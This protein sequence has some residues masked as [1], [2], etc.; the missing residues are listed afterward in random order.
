MAARIA[1]A[2][3][4][5][6]NVLGAYLAAERTQA[7]LGSSKRPFPPPGLEARDRAL[8]RRLAEGC[9]RRRNNLDHIARTLAKG[10]R[11]RPR[12]VEAALWIGIYELLFE[13]TPARAAVFEAVELARIGGGD[14]AKRFVNALLRRVADH[15][16]LDHWIARPGDD[17]TPADFATY[18]SYPVELCERWINAQGVDTARARLEQGNEPAPLGLRANP[19]KG[20]RETLLEELRSRGFELR[21]LLDPACFVVERGD[22]LETPEFA[23][24]RFSVQDAAQTEITALLDLHPGQRVLDY[25][26][27][28]GTKTIAIA[29]ALANRGEVFAFDRELERLGEVPDECRRCGVDNVRL[30]RSS[31]DLA[32]LVATCDRV[33]VD[34]PCSNTGVLARRAEAR[35]RFD[36]AGLAELARTQR[37]IL[38]AASV[39][40]K[41]G[42]RLVY[43]TCSLEAEENQAI[44]ES[45]AAEHPEFRLL[46]AE[47]LEPVAGAHCGGAA[48]VFVREE[49]A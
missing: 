41:P 39:H 2:R 7:R 34:A 30:L 5:A 31:D 45:F 9:V 14:G 49:P 44:A 25:C 10:K 6:W 43:A 48:A 11:P 19:L 23:A 16:E 26:A 35:W 47:T 21:P 24:G 22:V 28:P 38:E 12:G 40:T 3:R 8:A 42:A 32:E 15:R 18:Y 27:A 46:Y 1:P 36:P 29:E 13:N 33:L 37:E 4:A 17:A 20:D